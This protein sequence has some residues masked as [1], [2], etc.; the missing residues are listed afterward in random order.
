MNIAT[1][2]VASV[3]LG[4][5]DDDTIH[6]INR[7]RREMAEGATTDEAI[8][9]ATVHEGRASLTTAIIN[10]CGF[11]VLMLSEYKPT[12][13]FGGL[14]ALT[15]A[16]AFLA[17]VFILPATI[18]L[19]PRMFGAA[20]LRRTA[21]VA[22]ASS[23][24]CSRLAAICGLAQT[25]DRPSGYLSLFADYFPNRG[26]TTELPR[27]SVCRA[28]GQWPPTTCGLRSRDSPR[29]WRPAGRSVLTL[30]RG[31]SERCRS[32]MPTKQRSNCDSKNSICTPATVGSSGVG[33]DELQPTDVINPLDISRFFFDGRSKARLPVAVI[34]GQLFLHPK[35][36]L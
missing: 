17:E 12:A 16:V 30:G 14:L 5:V 7:Y 26:D 9:I 20:A 4:V 29:V 22:G 23:A 13:W 36:C 21:V 32:R 35:M 11:G 27:P 1:V 28:E 2:M 19:M 8:E 6:F 31:T 25:F 18:K 15:M 24:V 34:R 3:A 33:L 10:S